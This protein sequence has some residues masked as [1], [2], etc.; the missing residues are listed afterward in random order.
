MPWLSV[1]QTRLSR[2]IA[3]PIPLFALDVQRAGTPGQPGAS[4]SARTAPS[5]TAP[6]RVESVITMAIT[7]QSVQGEEGDRAARSTVAGRN[8]LLDVQHRLHRRM[9]RARV[10]EL[11]LLPGRERPGLLRLDDL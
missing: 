9:E 6:A 1:N 3:V 11:P 4:T 2:L 10:G 5:A 7:D 8:E